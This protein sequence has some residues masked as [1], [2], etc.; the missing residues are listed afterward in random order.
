[1]TL[2]PEVLAFQKSLV[3]KHPEFIQAAPQLTQTCNEILADA[4]G[5]PLLEPQVVCRCLTQTVAGSFMAMNLLVSHGFGCDAL[6][7]VRS[8]F[9]TS[10]I[11]ASFDHFPAL[12]QDY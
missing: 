5:P 11:L 3:E 12:I 6:K 2:F 10:V 4:T 1:M 8:M 7:I 9:E